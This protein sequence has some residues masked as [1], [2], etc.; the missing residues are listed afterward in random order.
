MRLFISYA[1]LYKPVVRQLVDLLKNGGHDPWYDHQLT[2]GEPW[3]DQLIA[4]IKKCD[5]FIY[6]LTP[7]SVNS[8]YCQWEFKQ[9]VEMGKPVLPILAQADTELPEALQKI[10]FVDFS[11]GAS[12]VNTARL[13][14]GLS[15]L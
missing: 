12:P 2:P 10:E 15:N 7:E 11:D 1:R 8:S 6:V 4:A 9:A 3:E 13:M 5:V 14:G